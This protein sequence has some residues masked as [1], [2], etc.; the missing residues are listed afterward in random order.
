MAQARVL[1][2][3]AGE[4][5]DL[6]RRRVGVGEQLGGG[7]R[8]LELAG[9]QVRVDG[10]LGAR[11]RPCPA[12]LSTSSARSLWASSKASP[13]GVRVED[14]LDEPGAV[15]QV[16]EDQAAVVAAAVHPAGDAGLG[17]DPVA[18]HLAAPGVAVGVRRAAPAARSSRSAPS[19]LELVEQLGRRRSARCSPLSMSRSCADAVVRRGS[20]TR[21]AP[22]RSACLSWPLSAAAGEVDLGREPGAAQLARP[23]RSAARSLLARR[24]RR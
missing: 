21:R 13:R 17:V 23:A 10:L 1:A 3:L 8:E 7:D 14:E 9:R 6:E 18:E 11:G 20:A 19:P 15:A 24:R 12:A 2:D 5:L 16:D 22:I 4:A